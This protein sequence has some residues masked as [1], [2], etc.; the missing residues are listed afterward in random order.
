MGSIKRTIERKKTKSAQKDIKKQL[1]KFD[2]IGDECSACKAPFDRKSKEQALMWKVVVREKENIVRLYCP[3]CWGK[4]M[5]AIKQ[6][7]EKLGHD[8][9]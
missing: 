5:T 2:S 6:I 7:E 1:N 4:A 3:D 9:S 8:N